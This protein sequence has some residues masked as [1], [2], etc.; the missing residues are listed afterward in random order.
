MR[1]YKILGFLLTYP[2]QEHQAALEECLAL[3]RHEKILSDKGIS[4]LEELMASFEK[5]DLLDLQDEYVSLFDRTPSLSLHLFEHIHGDSRERGQALVDLSN[6]YAEAGL[7]ITAEET[8]DYLP[9][10]LEYISNLPPSDVNENLSSVIDITTAIG[11]RLKNR[12]SFYSLVF[13]ALSEAA[14]CKANPKVVAAALNKASGEAYDLEQLDK[15]W[16]EQFAFDNTLPI[17]GQNDDCPRA[18]EMLARMN[19][20]P[21]EKEV[22]K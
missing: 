13:D 9:L 14:S 3:L 11:E 18:S 4:S 22:R 6:V 12:G 19:I 21:E 17:N 15:E 1:T 20:T 8:P 16:E 5:T 2:T 10:F 7:V